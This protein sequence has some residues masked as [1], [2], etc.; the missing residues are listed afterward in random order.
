MLREGMRRAK[1]WILF[2]KH[3]L[4][5][6]RFSKQEANTEHLSTM[7][8]LLYNKVEEGIISLDPHGFV[9]DANPGFC[10]LSGYSVEELRAMP[11]SQILHMLYVDWNAIS[12]DLS[13][14]GEWRGNVWLKHKTKGW[15]PFLLRIYRTLTQDRTIQQLAIFQVCHTEANE[16]EQLDP[17]TGLTHRLAFEN[18]LNQLCKGLQPF[19]LLTLDLDNFR[20]VNNKY[21]HQTGDRILQKIAKRLQRIVGP[22]GMISR[23]GGDD[24]AVLLP[25]MKTPEH[26]QTLAEQIHQS[27]LN[28]Y[29]FHEHS[30][31]V[32]GT[33]GGALWPFDARSPSALWR[34]AEQAMFIARNRHLPMLAFSPAVRKELSYRQRLQQDLA[35]A[36][37]NNRIDVYYQPI[38]DNQNQQIGKLE[39]LARW[40]HPQL[41]MI[42]PEI[43]IPLAEENGLI[44]LLGQRVLEKAARE[45]SR[46]HAKGFHWLDMSINRSTLEFNQIDAADKWI[47][48]LDNHHIKHQHFIFEVTESLLMN[49]DSLYHD[50]L[51]KL[52]TAGCKIAIDDFGTGYSS[53]NYLKRFPIDYLKIDRSF[54]THVPTSSKDTHL[55]IGILNIAKNLEYE[56]VVEGV[57]HAELQTFLVQAGCEFSQG[58]HFSKPLDT[59]SLTEFLHQLMPT[60]QKHVG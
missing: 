29:V 24:F 60:N 48:V 23:V 54:V 17:L 51:T 47:A 41:G 31:E 42:S 45:L 26:A 46:L 58:Y 7:I 19:T 38:W 16:N 34:R 30:I 35:Q 3:R 6:K 43:F 37:N 21:D 13:Q 9:I 40:N 22:Q 10:V 5:V 1:E 56:V 50:S 25:G 18:E 52:R 11:R 33:I 53:F 27:V 49:D 8:S 14:Q 32:T 28:P 36:I 20:Q 12:S 15:Q 55:L 57:E 44:V 59:A 2:A 4:R 39:A